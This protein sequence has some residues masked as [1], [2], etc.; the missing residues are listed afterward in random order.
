MVIGFKP[1]RRF[2]VS[3]FADLDAT[4]EASMTISRSSG[5]SLALPSST[6]VDSPVFK[7]TTIN[8]GLVAPIKLPKDISAM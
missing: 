8:A 7:S 5:I 2:V 4:G 6:R 3:P 1:K